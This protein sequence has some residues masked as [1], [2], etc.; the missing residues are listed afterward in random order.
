MFTYT[1]VKKPRLA[2]KPPHGLMH[3]TWRPQYPQVRHILR[4]TS[5]Q[6]KLTV[7]APNDKYEQEADRVADKIV[8]MPDTQ[9]QTQLSTAGNVDKPPAIQRMCSECQDELQRMSIE[10][11]DESVL[12]AKG[13]SGTPEVSNHVE[14][15]VQPLRG[16]GNPLAKSE[17]AFF[18]PRFSRSFDDVRIHTGRQADAVAN[19]INAR[20]FTVGNDIAFANGEY[21]PDSAKSRHL[22][23]HELTHTVQQTGGTG[24]YSAAVPEY[25]VGNAVILRQELNGRWSGMAS[26]KNWNKESVP[27]QPKIVMA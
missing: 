14:S 3:G 18:E 27:T 11:D 9:V 22:L 10:E 1:T 7:G 16:G 17:A 6:P 8:T 12:Q 26:G 25:L 20:A 23:A 19:A 5:L 13:R 24:S 2:T 4:S 15:G 21:N